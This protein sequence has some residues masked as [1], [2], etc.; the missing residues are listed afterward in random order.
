MWAEQINDD[1]ID[2][3][4]WPRAG[5]TAERLWS[6]AGVN[7]QEDARYRLDQHSCRLRRRGIRS[8]PLYPGFCL[9]KEW[10]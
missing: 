4:I 10:L 2:E 8:S 1:V 6:A 7:D 5:A 3:R 9:T